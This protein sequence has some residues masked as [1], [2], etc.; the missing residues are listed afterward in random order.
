VLRLL[1]ARPA[2]I[3]CAFMVGFVPLPDLIINPAQ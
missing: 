2:L 1:N 3:A